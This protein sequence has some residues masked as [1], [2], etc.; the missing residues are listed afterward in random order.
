[1]V[2]VSV[3]DAQKRFEEL[4]D[5]AQNEPVEILQDGIPVAYVLPASCKRDLET[6]RKN[7]ELYFIA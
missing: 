6:V 4:I 3:E 2:S 5:I 7:R 1:M